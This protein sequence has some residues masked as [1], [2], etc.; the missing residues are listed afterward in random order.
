MG[1][2]S[3]ILLDKNRFFNYWL[4]SMFLP[5]RRWEHI[6]ER[7]MHATAAINGE[8]REVRFI[9]RKPMA[10]PAEGSGSVAALEQSRIIHEA[11]H[12]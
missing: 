8:E 12:G 7:F 1:V 9:G 2:F 5:V 4:G 11:I 10:S 3:G 6:N